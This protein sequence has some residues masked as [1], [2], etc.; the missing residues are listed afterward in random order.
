M[1]FHLFYFN[2][3]IEVQL[4]RRIQAIEFKKPVLF[5][6]GIKKIVLNFLMQFS[7]V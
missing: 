3:Q 6:S 1:N 4:E 7:C 2:S 5:T